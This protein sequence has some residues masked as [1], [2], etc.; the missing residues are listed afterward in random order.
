M[1]P[2]LKSQSDVHSRSGP[3]GVIEKAGDN[4]LLVHGIPA[5]PLQKM[6]LW[7]LAGPVILIVLVAFTTVNVTASVMLAL[8]LMALIGLLTRGMSTEIDLSGKK[9]KIMWQVGVIVWSRAY[10][11]DD[12]AT[13][14]IQVRDRLIEGYQSSV[15][16]IVFVGSQDR[17]ST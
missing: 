13:V 12:Y 4:I 9:I 2:N 16:S 5:D 6:S 1:Y 15:F 11:L 8:V 17:K 14:K 10:S 7:L 3:S